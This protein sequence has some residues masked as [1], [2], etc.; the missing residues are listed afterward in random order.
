[1]DR[2]NRKHISL[3]GVDYQLA[4]HEVGRD[5]YAQNYE[6][7]IGSLNPYAPV[8]SSLSQDI[9]L[10][11]QSDWSGGEGADFWD[12]NDPTRGGLVGNVASVDA[13]PRIPGKL[14]QATNSGTVDMT[15]TTTAAADFHFA[16]GQSVLWAAWETRARYSTNPGSSWTAGSPGLTYNVV[17]VAGDADAFYIAA[18]NGSGDTEIRK[19][20]T[21]SSTSV[22]IH[23]S[24]NIVSIECS[25]P[26]IFV[27]RNNGK[28]YK[29][30]L[31]GS[32]GYTD[33]GDEI[34]K[35]GLNT[36]TNAS[37]SCRTDR[38]VAFLQ[39]ILGFTEVHEIIGPK[40]T[41]QKTWTL[42]QGFTGW[43]MCFAGGAMWVIGTMGDSGSQLQLFA[44]PLSTGIPV[45]VGLID[46]G[47][48]HT[49]PIRIAP[50]WNNE[51]MIST[52]DDLV[53]IYDWARDA[54]SRL[55]GEGIAGYTASDI[56]FFGN[57]RILGMRDDD[58][59]FTNVIYAFDMDRDTLESTGTSLWYSPFWDYGTPGIT[60]QL[61]ALEVVGKPISA[62]STSVQFEYELDQSGNWVSAG[63]ASSSN[64]TT[65]QV[66]FSITTSATPRA[67]KKMRWR[68]TFTGAATEINSV[69]WEAIPAQYI[70]SWDLV[71]RAKNETSS[72]HVP[73]YHRTGQIIRSALRTLVQTGNPV[74]FKDYYQ[75]NIHQ[76]GS[77]DTNDVMISTFEDLG[78]TAN[79]EGLIK[80][81]LV[82]V[83]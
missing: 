22:F 36:T 34:Y 43:D 24:S 37:R 1:M 57:K 55:S 83:G 10:W 11:T 75:Y 17:D 20:T 82:K 27:L 8:D 63:T 33:W 51:I 2:V 67:F 32:L 25:G 28:V 40:W 7:L 19:V 29:F 38:G 56:A 46:A 5:A 54:V 81:K 26:Y 64:F 35:I 66:R 44:Y 52:G 70:R 72:N 31:T 78:E 60:K 41:G 49:T 16:V 65:G 73:G 62:A 9:L 77:V 74:A 6:S 80:I 69:R 12:P 71:V 59:T 61:S 14:T 47:V 13:C 50:G 53:F 18:G 45:N 58:S 30:D 39:S 48:G 4:F 15:V 3:A 79:G 68:A 23:H 42:P 76:F 21:S